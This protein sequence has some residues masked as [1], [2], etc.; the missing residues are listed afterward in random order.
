MLERFGRVFVPFASACAC[1]AALSANVLVRSSSE[2]LEI[3]IGTLVGFVDFGF[4]AR[5]VCFWNA[6]GVS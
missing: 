5:G 1:F 2:S 6:G 3:E 4:V